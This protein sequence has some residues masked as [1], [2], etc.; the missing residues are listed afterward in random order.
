MDCLGR[1]LLAALAMGLVLTLSLAEVD[2]AK[3]KEYKSPGRIFTL[4]YPDSLN[5]AGVRYKV[6]NLNKR[7]DKNY[8]KIMFHVEDFGEYL[9]IGARYLPSES[10]VEMDKDNHRDVLRNISEGSLF[11]WRKDLNGLPE[12][13]EE[14]FFESN[15]GEAM[16]RVY[17]A[18]NGS[19]LAQMRFTEDGPVMNR[20]DT[21]I[22]SLIARQDALV[23]YVFAQD[24]S[25]PDD[26]N[27]TSEQA[28]VTFNALKI[29][30]KRD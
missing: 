5:W 30:P 1:R 10:L 26:A 20:F 11:G 7:G 27:S 24:D 25:N 18:K 16:K 19:L 2:A 29:R 22:V 23:V 9:V 13:I 14:S 15:Y 6:N 4:K 17:R 8:D 21:Y 12:L 28:L 3:Q